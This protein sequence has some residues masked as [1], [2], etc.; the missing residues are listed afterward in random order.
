MRA[1]RAHR[2]LH[3]LLHLDPSRDDRRQAVPPR[4]SAAAELQVGA[5]RLSR[6]RLVDRRQRPARSAGRIG[7]TQGAGADAP[8]VRPDAAARLRARARHLHRRGQCAGRA[9]RRSATPK[10]TC[11][12][13]ACSTT[14]RRATSRRGN[15][16]R[17]GPF[18]SKNFA[19]HDLAVD[20]D[21]GGAGAVPP[22]V[23]ARPAGDPQ[24]LPYLDSPAN[25]ERRR[26]R[27]RARGL[28]ADREDARS[29]RRRRSGCRAASFRARV[30]DASR[31]WSRTTRS[32]AAT[33]SPA[34]CSAPA[35]CPGPTPDEAGSLLELTAG[36]KQPLRLANGETRTLPGRRRHRDHLR[37]WCEKPGAARIG[38]GE[39]IGTVL[40]ALPA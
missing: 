10:R 2:R 13:C 23:G 25:R 38:F 8:D 21:A 20:R 15:T 29:R 24:P 33:C 27:H 37:G 6:P 40:P 17:S 18:L 32:T 9:D 7:Q 28:A 5:D 35:R 12:A 19:T 3:R 11:S 22:R 1:A 4:Q 16:S 34:T 36:G 30:L 31:R 14:G 26:A 39:A